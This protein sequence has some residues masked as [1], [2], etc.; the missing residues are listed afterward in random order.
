M[1]IFETTNYQKY[2]HSRLGGGL[3]RRGIKSQFATALEC[4]G[5]YI[6][7]ILDG[8][9]HLSLE[10]GMRANQFFG[11]TESESE[12]FLMQIGFAR[13]GSRDLKFYYKKK[14]EN[15]QET[16]HKLSERIKDVESFPEI[17]QATYYSLWLYAAVDMA[18]SITSLQTLESLSKYFQLPFSTLSPILSFLEGC[19]VVKQEGNKWINT[20]RQIYLTSDSPHI[21]KHHLNWRLKAMQLIEQPQ[22]KNLHYSSV[23]SLSEKDFVR[24]KEHFIESVSKAREIVKSS[25]DEKLAA[26]CIDCFEL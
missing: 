6:T 7:R 21:R 24:L 12:F 19:G 9:A 20:G 15:L 22:T 17:T 16:H 8:L 14:L 26:Y 4:D 13:A 1:N 18:T 11:H 5:A 3:G 2:L 23:V 10:Q 25:K